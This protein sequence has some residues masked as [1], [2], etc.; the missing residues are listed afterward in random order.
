MKIDYAKIELMMAEHEMTKRELAK[1]CGLSV[2]SIGTV[3]RH[4]TCLPRTAG[5]LA[6]GLGVTVKD[7]IKEEN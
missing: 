5:R 2:S 3:E 7:I 4:G 1:K 6:K